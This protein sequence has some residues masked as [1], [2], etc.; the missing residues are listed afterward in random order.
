MSH[1]KAPRLATLPAKA[2]TEELL[3]E[4]ELAGAVIIDQLFTGDIIER[5]D[6]DIG[7]ALAGVAWCNTAEEG[8]GRDF[9]GQTT[10]R[11]HGVLNLSD[12]CATAMMHD[13]PQQTAR[14]WLGC[15]PQ[16]STAEVMAIGPGE[17]QQAKHT[18]AASWHKASLAGELLF[19]M[20]IALTDFTAKNGATVVAPGSHR[21]LEQ[22]AQNA[23]VPAVMGRGSALLYSGRVWHGGGQNHTDETRVG[24]YFGYIPFWLAPLENPVTTHKPEV[25]NG[26]DKS[27]QEF[28]GYH[29]SGFKAVLG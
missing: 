17:V 11:L 29:P 28:L 3:G 5:L 22:P 24:L 7:I 25:L 14:A 12:A 1:S 20:T 15:Q 26:L 21:A 6:E 13:V 8:Y 27:V 16:F 10:K 9:F 18:D 19:S 4:L 23:F 2:S